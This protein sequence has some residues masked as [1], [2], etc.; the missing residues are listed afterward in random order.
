MTGYGWTKFTVTNIC[1]PVYIEWDQHQQHT[2]TSASLSLLTAQQSE[3]LCREETFTSYRPGRI[4]RDRLNTYKTI[5]TIIIVII[6]VSKRSLH[7]RPERYM[8]P[9]YVRSR[10][11]FSSGRRCAHTPLYRTPT[12]MV[13]AGHLSAADPGDKSRRGVSTAQRWQRRKIWPLVGVSFPQ[14]AVFRLVPIIR[15]G[16]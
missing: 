2:L 16:T 6:I 3:S 4:Y 12:F 13:A 11:G 5:I 9:A 1:V 7:F 8:I 15:T 14:S 10:N